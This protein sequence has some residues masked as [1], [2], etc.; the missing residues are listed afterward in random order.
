[1]G[2]TEPVAPL[3]RQLETNTQESSSEMKTG[4]RTKGPQERLG[5]A[6][7]ELAERMNALIRVVEGHVTDET[8]HRAPPR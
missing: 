7:A 5:V 8:R 6:M 1:M 2:I 3:I 4:E